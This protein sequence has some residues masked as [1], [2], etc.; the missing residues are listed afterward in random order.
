MKDARVAIAAQKNDSSGCL[1]KHTVGK[2]II[3]NRKGRQLPARFLGTVPGRE[4]FYD[5]AFAGL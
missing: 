4:L 1:W 3:G 5:F 2:A